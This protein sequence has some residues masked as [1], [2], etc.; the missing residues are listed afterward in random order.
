MKLRVLIHK[1]N[2]VIMICHEGKVSVIA[3]IISL[4]VQLFGVSE[5]GEK[6]A[7]FI[8][9]SIFSSVY[10]LFILYFIILV[11]ILSICFK[12][13]DFQVSFKV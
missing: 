3:F 1:V 2:N 8:S 9:E 6:A 10:S 13:K 4:L 12:S 5:L 11:F 7:L